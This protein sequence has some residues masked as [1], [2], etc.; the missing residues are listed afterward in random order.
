MTKGRRFAVATGMA[1]AMIIALAFS[2]HA[3]SQ[4]MKDAW[5]DTPPAI[6]AGVIVVWL[7]L[8]RRRERLKGHKQE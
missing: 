8:D 7:A 2:R 1:L 4:G 3:V 5:R 6:V